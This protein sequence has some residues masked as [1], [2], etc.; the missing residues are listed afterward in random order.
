MLRSSAPQRICLR[1]TLAKAAAHTSSLTPQT[2]AH[3][4]RHP[5]GSGIAKFRKLSGLRSVRGRTL[6]LKDGGTQ[7]RRA[8]G[9]EYGDGSAPRLRIPHP[10]G[11][12]LDLV[13][14]GARGY[15]DAGP[16]AVLTKREFADT[17]QAKGSKRLD[18]GSRS[19]M[20]DADQHLC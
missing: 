10:R 19:V 12:L 8:S 2:G 17:Q 14:A 18:V 5:L 4:L 7:S 20:L 9:G 3:G 1:T 15:A 13:L 16:R 6:R 11:H